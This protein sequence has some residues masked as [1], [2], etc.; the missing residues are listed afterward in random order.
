[1]KSKWSRCAFCTHNTSSNN[2][3]SQ[4]LGVSRL[5]ARPGAQT[6]TLRSLPT[7]EFTEYVLAGGLLSV[8]G[9]AL[10]RGGSCWHIHRATFRDSLRRV[11]WRIE[12][13]RR[14]EAV[15]PFISPPPGPAAPR[16]GCSSTPTPRL[17]GRKPC[18]GP[19]HSDPVRASSDP[20][21]SG[22]LRLDGRAGGASRDCARRCQRCVSAVE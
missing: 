10:S 12:E 14:T 18:S 5:C 2:R 11:S 4:L 17:A 3:S 8:T 9:E 20:R 1:M 19:G 22:D 7:S 16:Q 21:V 15:I 6:S 13:L